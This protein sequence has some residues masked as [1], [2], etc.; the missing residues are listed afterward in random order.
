MTNQ[1][2][3]AYILILVLI[4][5]NVKLVLD[6]GK[7][8]NERSEKVQQNDNP[9]RKIIYFLHFHNSGGSSLCSL[10]NKNNL[11]TGPKS[12]NCNIWIG[13]KKP[14]GVMKFSKYP[15]S[16]MDY[17]SLGN[18]IPCCGQ[19]ISQQ[20][21]LANT[22]LKNIDFVANEYALPDSLDYQNYK[23]V[24]IMRN[25]VKRYLSHFAHDGSEEIRR[26]IKINGVREEVEMKNFTKWLLGQK[27]NYMVRRLCGESCDVIKRGGLR[28][29]HL[30]KAK[31]RLDSFE[32]VLILENFEDSLRI[33][34]HNFGW[35]N[36]RND[37]KKGV[38]KKNNY[39]AVE[40]NKQSWVD[41]MNMMVIFDLELYE[42]AKFLNFKQIHKVSDLEKQYANFG[43]DCQ[44]V[45][46]GECAA[47]TFM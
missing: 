1:L 27:D 44:D 31:L 11:R 8:S 36:N 34:K 13:A 2:L 7:N 38:S 9:S 39:A 15:G 42:Y 41:V 10:A 47:G 17:G 3:F 16:P 5:I 32:A 12:Q 4:I 45:C 22:M 24:T 35:N 23:Y 14:N 26:F 25:P 28:R 30:E 21:S 37:N 18:N 40:E 43:K 33:L 20:Q 46:C 29:E 19:N 6:K